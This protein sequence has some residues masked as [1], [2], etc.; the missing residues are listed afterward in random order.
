VSQLWADDDSVVV[1][2]SSR[3]GDGGSSTDSDHSSDT[4]T[5]AST[6]ASAAVIA[7]V[8]TEGGLTVDEQDARLGSRRC[9]C[10]FPN[11]DSSLRF[12]SRNLVHTSVQAAQLEFAIGVGDGRRDSLVVGRSLNNSTRDDLS[13]SVD[14]FAAQRSVAQSHIGDLNFGSLLSCWSCCKSRSLWHCHTEAGKADH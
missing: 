3:D 4:Q 13:L 6:V 1:V 7:A 11:A 2:L 10:T 8:L 5:R 14:N 9:S 12:A